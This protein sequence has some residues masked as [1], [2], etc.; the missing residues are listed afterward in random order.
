MKS[1]ISATF[2]VGFLLM[3]GSVS[4]AGFC[5]VPDV[6]EAVDRAEAVFSG[7]IVAV[8]KD[9]SNSPT[10]SSEYIVK[11][12]VEE[13]W[14]GTESRELRV[15]WRPEMFGCSHNP[16][17]EMGERYL[18]YAESPKSD[19]VGKGRLLEITVLNRT[20]KIPPRTQVFSQS[21]SGNRRRKRLEFVY[22]APELDRNDASNDIDVLRHIKGCGCLLPYVLPTCMDST[23]TLRQPTLGLRS[24]STT[25]SCCAC[26]RHNMKS[27]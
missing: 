6:P 16:V 9:N 1:W 19:A 24:T 23:W 13:W 4:G 7:K 3:C 21:D 10:G 8:R 25:S 5:V 26:L 15:L 2:I 18:V 20:G 12:E 27:F 22:I 14:K 11:F 17:G